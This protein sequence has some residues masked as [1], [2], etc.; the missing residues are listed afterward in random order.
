MGTTIST[1]RTAD[2]LC[3]MLKEVRRDLYAQREAT[4]YA[5]GLVDDLITAATFGRPDLDE[6][7]ETLDK[8]GMFLAEEDEAA[9]AAFRAIRAW[10]AGLRAEGA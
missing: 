2:T 8:I 6:V 10:L 1:T 7:I 9:L 3:R 4:L 5:C